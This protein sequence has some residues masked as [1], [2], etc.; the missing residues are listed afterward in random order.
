MEPVVQTRTRARRLK[1]FSIVFVLA[2]WLAITSMHMVWYTADLAPTTVNGVAGVHAHI[3]LT[4]QGMTHLKDSSQQGTT[5]ANRN[6]NVGVKAGL[7][8]PVFFVV[9]AAALGVVGALLSSVLLEISALL[10]TLWAWSSLLNI[11]AQFENPNTLGG[12][13]LTRQAGQQRLWL[14]LTLML[15]FATLGI[16]QAVLARRAEKQ[17]RAEVEE[18]RTGVFANLVGA[19]GAG[20]VRAAKAS[21][22]DP[23]PGPETAAGYEP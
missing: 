2:G 23:V 1:L 21:T 7:I 14:A 13:T 22:S 20:M 18:E 12:F 17:A 19:L 16:I 8:D 3:S 11:R 5:S 4:G 6:P 9:A 15:A 10:A